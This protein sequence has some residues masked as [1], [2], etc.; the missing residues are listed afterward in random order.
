MQSWGA[1]EVLLIPLYAILDD[2]D[3]LLDHRLE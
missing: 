2:D 1:D 3:G